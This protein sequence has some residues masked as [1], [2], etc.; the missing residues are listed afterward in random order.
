[1]KITE[2]PID[3]ETMTLLDGC[4]IDAATLLEIDTAS[5]TSDEIIAAIDQCVRQ[6]QEGDG[7][8]VTEEDDPALMLGSL[9]GQRL[10]MEFGWSWAG[11]TFHDHNEMQAIGVFS[12]DRSLAIYPFHFIWGCLENGEAVAIEMAFN[13]LKDASR[14]PALPAG[15]YENVMDHAHDNDETPRDE[16]TSDQ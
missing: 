12:P 11:V 10:I 5:V 14:I 9:W 4:A 6:L 8:H 16:S 2:E 1:M 7:P 13:I 15:G 3:D